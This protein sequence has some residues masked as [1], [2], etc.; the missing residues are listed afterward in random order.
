MGSLQ[1]R[2][3][4]ARRDLVAAP[5]LHAPAILLSMRG[6]H[7]D[8]TISA[9]VCAYNEAPTSSRLSLF[10]ARPDPTTRRNPRRQQR[11][12][13]RDG[14]RG[15]RGAGRPRG[16]RTGQGSGRRARDR[17]AAP[18]G[19]ILAYVDADCRAPLRWLER[20]ERRFRAPCRAGRGDRSVSLLRLGLDAAARCIRAYDLLVA[21]PTHVARA[22]RAR[23]RR[24]SLRRQFRGAARGAR[25]D[26]RIRPLDRI[27]RR[28]HESR[29]AADA[30]RADR[31][32]RRECWVWTSA[33]RY[34]AMGKRTVFGL[35]VRNFWSEI[36]RHRPADRDHLDVRA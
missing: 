4:I 1:H 14:R 34:R 19:E 28:G 21:P 12:H 17:R 29:P 33:R 36:L 10:P 18:R 23:H 7:A 15:A 5:P 27:P 6:T 32:S 30:A 11:Q 8:L 20:V 16:R 2:S 35:Y 22:P 3:S 26:R 13:R 24:D 25:A 9:I 31:R